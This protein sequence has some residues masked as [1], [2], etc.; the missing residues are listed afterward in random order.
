[1]NSK[2]LGGGEGRPKAALQ[3]WLS[4]SLCEARR[5]V[6]G[7]FTEIVTNLAEQERAGEYSLPYTLLSTKAAFPSGGTERPAWQH[8]SG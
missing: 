6:L 8:V 2:S 3:V 5:Q 1:M 4:A 7:V